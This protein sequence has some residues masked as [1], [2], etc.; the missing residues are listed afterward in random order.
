MNKSDL[1]K[2]I[3]AAT[4]LTQDEAGA[5]LGAFQDAVIAELKAGGEVVLQGFGTFKVNAKA[6]R[7]GINP[8]TKEKIKI[9]ASKAPAFK[10]GP[11]FKKAL[12]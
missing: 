7:D 1:I 12:N 4:K 8:K 5:A 10:A 9:A 6:A 3:A 2:A 11:A